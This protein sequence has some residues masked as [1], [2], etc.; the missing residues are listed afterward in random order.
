M[1]L[2]DPFR[3]RVRAALV[4]ADLDEICENWS[5][6]TRHEGTGQ[7]FEHLVDVVAHNL[8]PLQAMDLLQAWVAASPSGE[9]RWVELH[10][11]RVTLVVQDASGVRGVH[12]SI[13]GSLEEAVKA[14]AG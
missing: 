4:S 8:R 9:F 5:L 10:Q 2:P 12:R 7:G 6:P 1:T 3:A 13:Y 11:G 14:L